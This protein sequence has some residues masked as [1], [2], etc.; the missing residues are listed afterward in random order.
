MRSVVWLNGLFVPPEEA[1]LPIFDAAVQHGIGLFETMRAEHGRL[2][3]AEAHLRRLEQSARVLGLADSLSVP[4][5]A[6]AA[7]LTVERCRLDSARVR[8]TVTGGSINLLARTQRTP[9]HRTVAIAAQPL[10]PFSEENYA[11]G[12]RVQVAEPRVSSADPFAGH[13][14]INYWPRL[15]VLHQTGAA[16]A[17]EALWFTTGGR[18]VGASVGNAF[19][20]R[21]GEI[22][23]P[24]ARSS[25][26][27]HPTLPGITRA[28]VMEIAAAE[29]RAVNEKPIL[30]HDLLGAD[31]IFL[32]NSM[33]GVLPVSKLEDRPVGPGSPGPVAKR[34]REGLR[35]LIESETRRSP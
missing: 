11:I 1:Q 25:T 20:V 30:M 10:S 5:L 9:A 15:A 17:D 4:A 27:S 8:I 35:D 34:M 12:V 16:G 23:T 18:L 21:D 32:T 31:E 26:E 2:F 14:T 6:Q 19:V 29:G 13:K 28:A 22:A 24:P 7:Q 33:W 3:R